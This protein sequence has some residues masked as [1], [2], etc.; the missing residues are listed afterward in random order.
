MNRR[1]Y[2]LILSLVGTVLTVVLAVAGGL[3]LWGYRFADSNVRDQLTSQ[4]I[5]FPPAGSPA[6][7]SDEIG[8]YLNRYAGQQ[9]TTGAQAEAYADHFI[10]VHL[11]E[12]AGGQTY[13]QVSTKAQ[14]AP[15]DT[16]LQ[17][18]VQTLFRGETL[19]GLLLNAYAFWKV[20][21]IAKWASIAAFLSAVATGVLTLFGFW[22]WTRLRPVTGPGPGVGDGRSGPAPAGTNGAAEPSRSGAVR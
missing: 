4:Q 16:Q 2:D 6:L 19:R 22:H 3:L 11:T 12:V 18:Q 17:G 13:S 20:G 8:P 5:F 1:T 21:Q 14:A 9:L 10:A 15:N 7:A